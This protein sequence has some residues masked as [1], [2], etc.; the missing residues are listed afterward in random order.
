MQTALFHQFP[1][2]SYQNQPE[3]FLSRNY[4][5][6]APL[7]DLGL[8]ESNAQGAYV[9]SVDLDSSTATLVLWSGVSPISPTIPREL[10]G[11]AIKA[12]FSR[13]TPLV[14]HEQAWKHPGFSALPEFRKSRFEGV[15]SIPLLDSGKVIGLL[16]V[17]RSQHAGLKPREFSFLLSLSVP[18]GALL[19]AAAARETLQLEVEKLTQ[20]LAD[21]KLL[22]RAKGVIQ[23]R[24]EWT[25]EQ[26]YL[27]I[28]KLSRRRRTPMRHIAQEVITS[29]ASVISAE[30]AR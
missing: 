15:V 4:S 7:L 18:I 6:I 21:R 16:N 9:Y 30:A 26:A 2:S 10:E 13:T 20:Q 11:S 14:F 5:A 24:F 17:C 27:C 29:A 23:S 3:T 19:A 28:R 1:S 22:E 8:T 12:G 25:E